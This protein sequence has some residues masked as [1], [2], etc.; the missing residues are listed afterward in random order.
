MKLR[1]LY[2]TIFVLSASAAVALNPVPLIP[3]PIEPADILPAINQWIAEQLNPTLIS[4]GGS[5]NLTQA[6]TSIPINL[7]SQ[8]TTQLIPAVSNK[9]I[10]VTSLDIVS[11]GT[12]TF[13]FE[14]GTQTTNPCDTGTTALTGPYGLVAQF[15]VAKGSG[16]GPVLVVPDGYALCAVNSAAIQVSGSLSYAQF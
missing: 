1:V 4:A 15:G 10:Y 7:S 16:T 12:T 2:S 8:A 5:S 3:G 6:T 14:Y 13:T 9:A 11:N